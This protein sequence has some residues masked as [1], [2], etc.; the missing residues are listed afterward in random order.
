VRAIGG[1]IY[2][3]AFLR[4]AVDADVQETAHSSSQNEHKEIDKHRL[5]LYITD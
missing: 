2:Y 5:K 4:Q 1:R 3:G